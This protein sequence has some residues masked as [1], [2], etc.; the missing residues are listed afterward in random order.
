MLPYWDLL[1]EAWTAWLEHPEDNGDHLATFLRY[2]PVR[3]YGFNREPASIQLFHAEMDLHIKFFP[4]MELLYVLLAPSGADEISPELLTAA[5]LFAV[6]SDWD[7]PGR[8]A[9]W[10]RLNAIEAD[11]ESYPELARWLP[12]LARWACGSTDNPI[13]KWSFATYYQDNGPRFAWDTD[14]EKARLAWQEAKPVIEHLDLLLEWCR[15]RAENLVILAEFLT[16]GKN[17][18]R[19]T[20]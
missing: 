1:N 3:F 19:L 10:E 18:E 14:V 7:E 12:A 9:A 6:E 13:L 8:G 2:I 5:K 4:P 17:V 15:E 16:S 11:P 20:F